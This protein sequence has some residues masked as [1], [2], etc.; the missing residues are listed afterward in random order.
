[1]RDPVSVQ[2]IPLARTARAKD[3]QTIV[4]RISGSEFLARVAHR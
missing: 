1:V 3:G 4:F 2:R